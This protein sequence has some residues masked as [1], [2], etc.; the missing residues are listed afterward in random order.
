MARGLRGVLVVKHRPD[1][2]NEFAGDGHGHDVVGFSMAFFEV[3]VAF[4]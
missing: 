2:S 3:I 1:E 4:V